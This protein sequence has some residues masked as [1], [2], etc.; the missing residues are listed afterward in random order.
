MF[1]LA[2]HIYNSRV[3]FSSCIHKGIQKSLRRS[4]PRTPQHCSIIPFGPVVTWAVNNLNCYSK[5]SS[6][7]IGLNIT[8]Q[9]VAVKSFTKE[10]KNRNNLKEIKQGMTFSKVV[11]CTWSKYGETLNS[12]SGKYPHTTASILQL[13]LCYI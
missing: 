7:A 11:L 2:R 1:L 9:L 12:W 5:M 10:N 6:S 3:I 4:K 8:F 13:L